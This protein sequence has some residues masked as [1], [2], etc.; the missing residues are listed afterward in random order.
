MSTLEYCCTA[1]APKTQVMTNCPNCGAPITGLRCEYCGTQFE[2]PKTVYCEVPYSR[3]YNDVETQLMNLQSQIAEANA[4]MANSIQTQ[5]LLNTLGRWTA[6]PYI[7]R[8]APLGTI[9]TR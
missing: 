6:W 7:T 9:K 8:P 2:K 4:R 5:Y 1:R 3:P